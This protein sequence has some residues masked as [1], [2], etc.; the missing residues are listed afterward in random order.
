VARTVYFL[1]GQVGNNDHW[2][3]SLGRPGMVMKDL[4]TYP[5]LSCTL[6]IFIT[7]V[8][9]YLKSLSPCSSASAI[10]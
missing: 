10:G 5:R 3:V 6:I 2:P 1:T 9:P 7:R 8:S 4:K